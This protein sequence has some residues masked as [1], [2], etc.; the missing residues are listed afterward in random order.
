MTRSCRG[1]HHGQDAILYEIRQ[2]LVE[3]LMKYGL[4][5]IDK[6]D[7][8]ETE[9]YLTAE[10]LA[11]FAVIPWSADKKTRLYLHRANV[12]Q[13]ILPVASN[14]ETLPSE[15]MPLLDQAEMKTVIVTAKAET[16]RIQAQGRKP[17][18]YTDHT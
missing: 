4:Q 1:V 18:T 15:T 13:L 7:V 14:V 5:E 6:H 11:C 17:M 10:V 12:D 2:R 9:L 16:A 3:I 8:G